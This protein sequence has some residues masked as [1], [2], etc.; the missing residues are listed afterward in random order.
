MG[1]EDIFYKEINQEPKK[2]ND[3]LKFLYFGRMVHYKGVDLIIDAAKKIQN[4]KW[5]TGYRSS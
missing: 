1:I 5:W 2:N 4:E 3:I